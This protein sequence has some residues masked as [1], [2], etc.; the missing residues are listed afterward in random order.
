MQVA[1]LKKYINKI[2]FFLDQ[3]FFFLNADINS[4][5]VDN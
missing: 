4:L 5:Q 1:T 3:N 2:I